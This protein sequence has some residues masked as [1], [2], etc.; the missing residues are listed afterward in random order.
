MIIERDGGTP[1]R[2]V[3]FSGYLIHGRGLII[4][5]KEFES[6]E[7]AKNKDCAL[8]PLLSL[9][10]PFSL[11]LILGLRFIHLPICVLYWDLEVAVQSH[12][13]NWER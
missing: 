12:V 11:Y 5:G 1:K 7:R 4:L 9:S 13:G 8:R 3:R 10:P 6:T 2:Y